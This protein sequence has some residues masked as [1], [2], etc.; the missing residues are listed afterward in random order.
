MRKGEDM[1]V[2]KPLTLSVPEAGRGTFHYPEMA[3]MMRPN[4]VK[5]RP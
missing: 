2:S 3:P 5:F 1:P 4:A